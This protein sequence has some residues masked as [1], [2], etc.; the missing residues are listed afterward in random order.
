MIFILFLLL[1]IFLKYKSS[2]ETQKCS[3]NNRK[4]FKFKQDFKSNFSFNHSI[5]DDADNEWE[6]VPDKLIF[7]RRSGVF[8]SE[9][10]SL[11]SILLLVNDSSVTSINYI[12]F[13]LSVING[14]DQVIEDFSIELG[15]LT[16]KRLLSFKLENVD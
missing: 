3:N 4:Y 13:Y 14:C 15:N 6:F 5:T 7:I 16:L 11:I 2:N 8:Y 1:Q 12:I 10:D 9:N